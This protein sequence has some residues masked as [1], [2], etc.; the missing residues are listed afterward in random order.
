[1][2]SKHSFGMASTQQDVDALK[3]KLETLTS[4]PK[5]KYPYPVTSAQDVGWDNDEVRD[6]D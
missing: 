3:K 1:M 4:V 2:A 6:S 5:K